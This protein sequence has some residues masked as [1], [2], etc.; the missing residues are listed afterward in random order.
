MGS[1]HL[2]KKGRASNDKIAQLDRNNPLQGNRF[3]ALSGDFVGAGSRGLVQTKVT[4]FTSKRSFDEIDDGVCVSSLKRK[5]ALAGPSYAQKTAGGS[6]GAGVA[7][8]QSVV[9]DSSWLANTDPIV[10][11]NENSSSVSNDGSC[12]SLSEE[13]NNLSDLLEKDGS[14]LNMALL[15]FLNKLNEGMDFKEKKIVSLEKEVK[16][17]FS[18][19]GHVLKRKG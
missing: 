16:K 6:G 3:E 1:Q 17:N 14:P 18:L 2:K 15:I 5:A 7:L 8:S 12:L 13:M 19:T 11:L 4:A 9:M 10:N